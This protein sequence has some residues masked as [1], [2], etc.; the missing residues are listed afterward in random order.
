MER[1]GSLLS[2]VLAK[3]GLKD[4][5][6]ASL[7]VHQAQEWL[8]DALPPFHDMIH[9]QKC[10]NGVLFVKC[11]HSIAAQECHQVVDGL[12][13]YLKGECGFTVVESVRI[14]R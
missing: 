12:L 4:Q 6:I 7:I 13:E 9:V 2:K 3:R 10:E 5:A 14:M 11:E 1:V 8:V